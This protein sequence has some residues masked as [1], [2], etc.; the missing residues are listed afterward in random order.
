MSCWDTNGSYN[1]IGFS[2]DEGNWYI[3]WSWTVTTPSGDLRYTYDGWTHELQDGEY[4]R[5]TMRFIG[6]GELRFEVHH[7]STLVFSHSASTGGT[8][9]SISNYFTNSHNGQT[10]VDFTC[11]EEITNPLTPETPVYDFRFGNPYVDDAEFRGWQHSPWLSSSGGASVP[12]G[13]TVQINTGPWGYVL[14]DNPDG[15]HWT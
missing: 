8:Y 7:G 10:Y 5:F 3:G 11:Y 9:F 13:V 15:S 14:V 1:Q 6:G 4:Y 12:E 2:A